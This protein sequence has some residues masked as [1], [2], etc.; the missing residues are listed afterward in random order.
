MAQNKTQAT[1][2]DPAVF[3]A[4]VENETRRED[5]QRLMQLMSRATGE[6]A[7]MWGA[8]IVGFGEFHYISD[9]GREGDWMMVGFAPRKAASVVYLLDGLDAHEAALAELGPHTRGKGC[10]YLK[11]LDDVDLGVLEGMVRRTYE[12]LT[13]Q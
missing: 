5:A 3:L 9:A 12:R 6:P 4:S 10:L 7:R 11:K 13:A 2:A 8:S 1:D